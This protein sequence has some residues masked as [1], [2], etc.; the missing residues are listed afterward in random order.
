MNFKKSVGS[1]FALDIGTTA[2]RVVELAHSSSGWELKH[3][4]SKPI[5]PRLSE[6][7]SEH[8]RKELGEAI[9]S[10]V[11]EAG[12]K[13]KDVVIGLPTSKIFFSVV[14]LPTMSKQ[15]LNN[16]IKYQMA[17]YVPL[18]LD[19]AKADW[20]IL[21]KSVNDSTKTE[22]LIMAA[23]ND[24]T[25]SR[26][27]F[28]E[29][30]GFSVIAIEPDAL[31]IVRSLLPD[32]IVDGRLIIDMGE[33]STDIIATLDSSPR[34]VRSIPIGMLSFVRIASRSLNIDAQ[35]A[36]Q[37]ILKFGVSDAALEGQLAHVLSPALSQFAA[38]LSKSINYFKS[39]FASS[40]L[41]GVLVSG[42]TSILSGFPELISSK[43]ELPVQ[44]ATPWQHVN[45]PVSDQANLAPISSQ[46]AVTVG[47]AERLGL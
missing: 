7:T 44:V 29:A 26:L 10:V 30:L 2:V 33:M 12:I 25:E 47:L 23:K 35:Q 24:Y 27:D 17:S 14:E 19:E 8:D 31:A 22:V 46:L 18:K 21:G 38:E 36:R 1:F 40:S 5:D 6:S 37:L 45:V 9:T 43:V 11:N 3:Y 39:R 28:I 20:S 15:E 32:G 16:T 34:L 13:T 41:S 42:Y 4:G